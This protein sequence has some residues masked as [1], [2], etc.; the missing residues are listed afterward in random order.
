M[1]LRSAPAGGIAS[2]ECPH[3]AALPLVRCARSLQHGP[4]AMIRVMRQ[5]IAMAC[6]RRA[7]ALGAT[8]AA[9]AGLTG[10]LAAVAGSSAGGGGVGPPG[11]DGGGG[12]GSGGGG[13]GGGGGW[14]P[15]GW[16]RR[17]KKSKV[18]PVTLT[19]VSFAVSRKAYARVSGVAHEASADGRFWLAAGPIG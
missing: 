19:L 4:A 1:P 8:A 13:S 9:A 17:D 11:A 15:F 3:A 7:A 5:P 6:H 2:G 12:G 10:Q 14:D 16:W 18:K